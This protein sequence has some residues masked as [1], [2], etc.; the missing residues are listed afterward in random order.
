[1]SRQ[2]LVAAALEALEQAAR[3]VGIDPRPARMTG[4]GACVFLPLD[5]ES[6]AVTVCNRLQGRPTPGS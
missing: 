6:A 5:S 1:M 2:P 3:D 4:S